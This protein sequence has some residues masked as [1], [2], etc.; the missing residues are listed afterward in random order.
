MFLNEFSKIV[1]KFFTR[2]EILKPHASKATSAAS[3]AKVYISPTSIVTLVDFIFSKSFHN[4]KGYFILKFDGTCQILEICEIEIW[5]S[6]L[7]FFALIN[8]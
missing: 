5:A 7:I 6:E 4:A 1:E 2:S 8:F 3:T